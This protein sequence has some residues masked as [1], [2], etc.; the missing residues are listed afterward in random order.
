MKNGIVKI[1][2]FGELDALAKKYK[3]N[4]GDWAEKSWDNRNDRSRIAELRRMLNLTLEGKNP[5]EVGRAFTTGK[6]MALIKGLDQIIGGNIVKKE[7]QK[8][9]A[10]TKDR[11]ERLLLM[12]M[13]LPEEEEPNVELYMKAIFDK[14]K[15]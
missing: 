1:E 4:A 8:I 15:K 6:C 9:F 2:I 11:K 3:V 10:K 5:S 14:P 7:L 12:V 13:S